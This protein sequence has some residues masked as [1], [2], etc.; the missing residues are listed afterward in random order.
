MR[1]RKGNQC[2]R[3]FIIV[4]QVD[5]FVNFRAPEAAL[6]ELLAPRRRR[7]LLDPARFAE[8][9]HLIVFWSSHVFAQDSAIPTHFA[10]TTNERT[11]G[12]DS[13]HSYH[14]NQHH[15]WRAPRTEAAPDPTIWGILKAQIYR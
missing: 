13:W 15:L 4:R 14:H 1:I 10:R 11:F 9:A 12:Q 6:P 7:V 2:L 3:G 5:A 8:P